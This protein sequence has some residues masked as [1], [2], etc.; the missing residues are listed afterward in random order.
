MNPLVLI[1]E[2]DALL[3][4]HYRR[5]LLR[6]GYRSKHVRSAEAAID[7]IDKYAPDVL[8][9]DMLLTGTNVMSLLNELQSHDDLA[10]I[11]VILAS[12]LAST[13]TLKDLEPYGVKSILDKS[14][15]QPL[16]IVACVRGLLE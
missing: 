11:P 9:V 6:Y 4:E 12:N 1:V 10:R 2:D 16:D 14:S 5:V 15:M 13:L 7:A 8:L 3:A